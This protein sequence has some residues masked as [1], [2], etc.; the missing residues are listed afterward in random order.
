MREIANWKCNG[1]SIVKHNKVH[2]DAE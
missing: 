2:R 1:A